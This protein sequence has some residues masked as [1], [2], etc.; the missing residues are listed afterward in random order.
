MIIKILAPAAI[1]LWMATNSLTL[2]AQD[3]IKTPDVSQESGAPTNDD[4]SVQEITDLGHD[5]ATPSTKMSAKLARIRQAENFDALVK[6]RDQLLAEVVRLKDEIKQLQA[7]ATKKVEQ[8]QT[9]L[10]IQLPQIDVVSRFISA[11]RSVANLAVG[12]TKVVVRED[13]EIRI[14]L[15]KT[16]TTVARV[17][18][19]DHH[20]IELEFPELDNR[21]ITLSN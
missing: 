4:L 8:R 2:L 11:D 15:S 14:P 16:N 17:I 5:P 3:T 10:T 12:E 19:I 9:A 7:A 18:K 13:T 21:Q 6:E 1:A 20:K